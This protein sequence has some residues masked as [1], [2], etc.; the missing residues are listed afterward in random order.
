MG[1]GSRCDTLDDH[2][3]DW[4]WKRVT[5]LG[6]IIARK[7]T[8]AIAQ[9]EDHERE[10]VALEL[11]LQADDLSIWQRKI[12]DWE[13]DSQNR[14]PFEIRVAAETQATV[15][16]ELAHLEATELESRTNS[17]L[18]STVSA[19]DLIST[20]IELEEQQYVLLI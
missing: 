13:R 8:E 12:E 5:Q 3:G 17:S 15:R 4:N 16:L 19:S 7:N 18:H 9:H 1:P 14:N 2:F 10:L 11:C 20:G 6:H